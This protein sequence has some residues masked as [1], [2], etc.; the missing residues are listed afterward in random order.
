MHTYN[1]EQGLSSAE[2]EKRLLEYGENRLPAA[3]P[4]SIV[5]IFLKQ[6]FSPFIYILLAAA[7]VS[8]VIKQIPSAIFII[9]V[10]LINAIIGTIQEYSA[11]KSASALK[12][13]VKGSSHVIRDGVAQTIDSTQVV[14]GDLLLLF[15]GDKVAAD[16]ELLSVQDL[17]VDESM[18]TGESL[19]VAKNTHDKVKS[20]AS[21]SEQFNRCFAGSIVTH[22]R[23]QG[24]VINTGINTEIGHI[25][26]HV[27]AER[28]SEPPLLI[29]M[30]RFTYKIAFA[31]TLSILVLVTLMLYMG[32]YQTDKMLMMAIGLAVSTIP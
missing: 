1:N 2:A 6:F 31:I 7:I 11:Q 5:L 27:S 25:A 21:I 3:P 18:L 13:M 19:A 17:A 22:G 20:D 24:I 23:A 30:R 4:T 32:G 9:A 15:S 12:Q 14:P 26:T 16:I 29:R 10:L 28:I 8:F